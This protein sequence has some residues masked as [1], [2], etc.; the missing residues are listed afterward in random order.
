M[1]GTSAALEFF[2]ALGEL[3]AFAGLGL[4]G[5]LAFH[6]TGVAGHEACFAQN[7]FVLGVDFHQ[8]AGNTQTQS[9][10]LAFVAATVEINVNIVFVAYLKCAE[11]LL[12]DELKNRRREVYFQ[13]SFVDGDNAGS[14]FQDYAGYG[15]FAAAYCIYCFH[16]SRDY[17]SLLI[18]STVGF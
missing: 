15:C 16:S 13:R 11:G 1:Q 7:G 9:F 2:S 3:E 10:G 17:F 18:S 6:G 12:Y 14:L 4:T 5:L 8:C